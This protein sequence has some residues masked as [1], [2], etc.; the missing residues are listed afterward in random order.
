MQNL[1]RI[2]PK[3]AV[4]LWKTF[5]PVFRGYLYIK[6]PP[7]YTPILIF[8]LRSYLNSSTLDITTSNKKMFK[9]RSFDRIP[10]ISGPPKKFEKSKFHIK[11]KKKWFKFHFSLII[12]QKSKTLGN[13]DNFSNLKCEKR[14]T[15][16]K[17]MSIWKMLVNPKNLSDLYIHL[18]IYF[19]SL[20]MVSK[21]SHIQQNYNERV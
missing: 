17:L 3:P 6:P 5:F 4:I 11:F 19:D 21:T 15:I 7:R 8:A 2:R 9:I 20:T 10:A 1:S 16:D 12:F 14:L 18:R 13:E